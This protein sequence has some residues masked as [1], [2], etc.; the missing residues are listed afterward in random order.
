M[1]VAGNTDDP[2]TVTVREEGLKDAGTMRVEPEFNP[3][4]DSVTPQPSV[5]KGFDGGTRS[6]QRDH[7]LLEQ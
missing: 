6:C 1:N 7:R 3:E 2:L 4:S 5:L